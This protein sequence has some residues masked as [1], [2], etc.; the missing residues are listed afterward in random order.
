MPLHT[1]V[2]LYVSPPLQNVCNGGS[3]LLLSVATRGALDYQTLK[4]LVELG[5][6][7][8]VL[9][10]LGCMLLRHLSCYVTHAALILLKTISC[11]F[12]NVYVCAVLCVGVYGCL[13]RPEEAV[14]ARSWSY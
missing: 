8:C 2:M 13:Q 3:T 5:S 6:Y 11:I 10:G 14:R 12:N 7:I 4:V 9:F 1:E